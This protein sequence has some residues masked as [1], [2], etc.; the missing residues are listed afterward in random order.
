M[1]STPIPQFPPGLDPNL[2][3]SMAMAQAAP[4]DAWHSNR[5]Q[6]HPSNGYNP[7]QHAF[8]PVDRQERQLPLQPTQPSSV[9]HYSQWQDPQTGVTYYNYSQKPQQQQFR[10]AP[11]PQQQSVNRQPL[12]NRNQYT[13]G[14]RPQTTDASQLNDRAQHYAPPMKELQP[15]FSERGTP[16][17]TRNL[18]IFQTSPQRY[19]SSTVVP[20][21]PPQAPDRDRTPMP[22]QT[23]QPSVVYQSSSQLEAAAPRLE[24]VKQEK[25]V[26]TQTAHAW[27][28]MLEVPRPEGI[29]N[30]R[31]I[32]LD[33]HLVVKVGDLVHVSPSPDHFQW[34]EGRV[35][36]ADYT[37]IRHGRMQAR[38]LVSYRDPESG[39]LKQR[40][41]CPH[42]KEILAQP[43][44][45]PALALIP[46]SRDIYACIPPLIIKGPPV[47]MRWTHACVL[48]PPDKKD[49]LAVRI[50]AGP[51][52]DYVYKKFPAKYTRPFTSASR[53]DLL[54]EGHCV[55]RSVEPPA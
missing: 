14:L 38:Y 54:T 33:P 41:F 39:R 9:A 35:E 11:Q 48:T 25:P 37:V 22:R 53:V 6:N 26:Q 43:I 5:F 31:P 18:R 46:E 13:G 30:P 47:E 20:G 12:P 44:D 49:L 10:P 4:Q 2:I 52:K 19:R 16:K 42:L 50:L 34:I 51:S 17:P 8:Q 3:Q 15:F 32:P 55:A 1:S 23:T 45:E 7:Q 21:V 36:K 24:V 28:N 40:I 29:Y 27:H